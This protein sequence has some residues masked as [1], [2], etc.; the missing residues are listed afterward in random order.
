MA[1]PLFR[2]FAPL[3][4][5]RQEI[6][7]LRAPS[8]AEERAYKRALLPPI[9]MAQQI[10]EQ[11]I[12]TPHPLLC[13][14][15]ALRV[16]GTLSS[17]RMRFTQLQRTLS[18]SSKTLSKRLKELEREGIVTRTLYAQVPLRVEYELTA[19]GYELRD[20]LASISQWEKKW[21]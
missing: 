5:P 6:F 11:V 9:R 16:I 13:D 7:K 4:S 15:W 19:K 21:K 20:I 3:D 17:S 10:Y 8:L 2:G 1:R 18:M 14:A 12:T